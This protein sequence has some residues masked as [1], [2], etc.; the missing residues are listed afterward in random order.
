MVI[1][2]ITFQQETIIAVVALIITIIGYIWGFARLIAKLEIKPSEEQ[3]KDLIDEKFANHCPFSSKIAQLETTQNKNVD[4]V[5]HIKSKIDQIDFN[6]QNICS[7]LD[8]EY[9]GKKNG[10]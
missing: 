5:A 9:I 8:V 3:V 7:K 4:N 10:N 2:E 6:V 1:A